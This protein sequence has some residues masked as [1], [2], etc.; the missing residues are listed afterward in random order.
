ML[1]GHM[2]LVTFAHTPHGAIG[3]Y[4]PLPLAIMMVALSFRKGKCF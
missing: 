3:N 2:R 1:A 4:I